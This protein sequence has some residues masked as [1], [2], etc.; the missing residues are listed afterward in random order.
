MIDVARGVSRGMQ[1]PMRLHTSPD[2]DDEYR[3]VLNSDATREALF[4]HPGTA[5]GFLARLYQATG[6]EEWLD[7]ASA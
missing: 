4:Y 6:E 7:L 1:V 5:S 3:Y 2:P